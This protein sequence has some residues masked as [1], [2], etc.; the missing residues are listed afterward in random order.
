MRI[1]KTFGGG[2]IHH[3]KVTDKNIDINIKDILI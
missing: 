2:F 3:D 1:P